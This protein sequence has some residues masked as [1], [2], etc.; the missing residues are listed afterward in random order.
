MKLQKIFLAVVA[1][2]GGPSAFAFDGTINITGRVTD[3]TCEVKT[4]T[5]NLSV[6]LPEVGAASLNAA[7]KTAGATSFAISLQ[8][9][10]PGT[11]NV[12]AF[13]EPGSTIVGSRLKN[14]ST[15]SPAGNVEIQLLNNNHT[16]ID[17]SQNTASGQF[18]TAVPVTTTDINLNYYAQYYATNAATPGEVKSTVNYTIVYN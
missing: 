12:T 15:N 4:G 16:P 14:T 8:G 6:Q 1:V 2:V 18:S 5:E 17:L 11:G 3:Q 13:F 7:N 10:N 9:C